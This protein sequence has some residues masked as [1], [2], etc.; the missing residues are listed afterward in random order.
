MTQTRISRGK[1]GRAVTTTA[2]TASCHDVSWR[3]SQTAVSSDTRGPLSLWAPR[4][5][6]PVGS[7][8]FQAS[9]LCQSR[10]AVCP[11]ASRRAP[12]GLSSAVDS[13]S[14]F[15]KLEGTSQ[16]KPQSSVLLPHLV[17]WGFDKQ[18]LGSVLQTLHLC[19]HPLPALPN[20]ARG[21]LIYNPLRAALSPRGL[22]ALLFPVTHWVLALS[23]T[24]LRVS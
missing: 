24:G 5:L 21:P 8:G 7:P 14:P 20:R 9:C 10:K 18:T 23:S 4:S 2:L 13:V 11:L 6:L 19:S 1:G 3:T 22:L 16:I 12:Q 17:L 15:W